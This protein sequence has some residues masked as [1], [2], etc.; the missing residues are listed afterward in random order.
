ME[1]KY[2]IEDVAMMTGM[3]TRTLRTYIKNGFLAGEK[4][5]GKWYF[6]EEHLAYF[7]SNAFIIEGIKV[8]SHIIVN[9]FIKQPNKGSSSSCFIQ[10]IPGSKEE[11][12]RI[13]N[14]LIPCI[15]AM[16]NDIKFSFYYDEKQML[17]R[18]IIAGN[19]K[20]VSE[21]VNMIHC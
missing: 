9:D 20:S 4:Q 14:R 17:G 21:I 5:N 1:K 8:K 11:M 6:T 15:H 19:A 13:H 16:E 18:F 12:E 2:T 7:Y 10:D 3:T